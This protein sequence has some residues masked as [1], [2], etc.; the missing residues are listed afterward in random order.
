V[1]VSGGYSGHGNVVGFMCGDLVARA[2]LG[3]PH[4]PLELFA[5]GRLLP[6]A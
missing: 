2:M 1:W 3:E 4:P 5:P 6:A